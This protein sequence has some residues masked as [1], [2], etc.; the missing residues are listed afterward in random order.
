MLHLT[1]WYWEGVLDPLTYLGPGSKPFWLI[2]GIIF[3][4]L[5]YDLFF[6]IL[7]QYMR[8][9]FKLLFLSSPLCMP[10]LF[11]KQFV[12]VQD[13]FNSPYF[14]VHILTP[15]KGSRIFKCASMFVRPGKKPPSA[16]EG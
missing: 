6:F 10:A 4:F 13:V 16:S 11:T 15:N 2:S 5:N 8:Q 3:L 12:I 14:H 7:F 1:I 9:G